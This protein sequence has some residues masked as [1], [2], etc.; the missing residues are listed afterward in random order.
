MRSRDCS[1]D[2]G[3]SSSTAVASGGNRSRLHEVRPDEAPPHDLVQT[4]GGQRIGGSPPEPLSSV[5]PTVGAVARGE[6]RRQLLEAVEPRDLLD[7]VG[8]AGDVGAA[9][10]GHGD[11]EPVRAPRIP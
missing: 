3:F 2:I 5:K 4:L 9:E 6:R 8:L 11:V 10:R 7:Q 1:V